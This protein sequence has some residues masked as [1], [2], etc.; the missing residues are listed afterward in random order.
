MA[1]PTISQSTRFFTR[2]RTKCYFLPSVSNLSS[3]TRAEMNSGVDLTP[4]IADLSG[5]TVAGNQIDTPDMGTTFDSKI[6][7]T[8]SAEDSSLNLYASVDGVD[9]QEDLPRGTTG[10]VM[11][12]DGGD[13]PGRKAD[14]YPVTVASN[15]ALR[16]MSEATQRQVNFAITSEP[17]EGVTI[18]A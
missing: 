13:V 5:W 16:S 4:Q 17:A 3:P 12:L 8:T 10:V 6:T 2:G 18:P 11:W 7:G 1:T 15:S 9:V 14:L